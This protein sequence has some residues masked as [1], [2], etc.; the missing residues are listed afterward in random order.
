[1]GLPSD[2]RE[3]EVGEPGEAREPLPQRRPSGTHRKLGG[4]VDVV[5]QVGE[6]LKKRQSRPAS[7]PVSDPDDTTES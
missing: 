4:I 2:A 5:S 6:R 1:M 7:A 3:E